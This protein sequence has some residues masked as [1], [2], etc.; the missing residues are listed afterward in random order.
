[1]PLRSDESAFYGRQLATAGWGEEGQLKLG[2]S[3]VFVAGLGGLGCPASVYL[4]T[5]GVGRLI[6]CDADSV[7][8]SNLNRQFLY[9][10]GDL[11]S[12]KALVA[13][14]RLRAINPMIDIVPLDAEIDRSKA[15]SLIAGADI[16]LDCLDNVETRVALSRAAIAADVPMVH[17]AVSEWTGYLSLFHPPATPCYECFLTR[18]PP[19]VEPPIPGCTAGV[20]GALQAMEALKFLTGIGGTLAGRL[21]VVEGTVPSFDVVELEKDPHCPACGDLR[22]T[23]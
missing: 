13:A 6:V 3:S 20:M 8:R 10:P 4:A 5:A 15:A 11:G 19:A 12:C 22:R 17:A 21:L 1:M 7:E 23:A 2:A 9:G 14:D 16:V 18:T